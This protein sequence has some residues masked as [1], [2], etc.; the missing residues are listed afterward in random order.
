MNDQKEAKSERPSEP[1]LK[2]RK[3]RERVKKLQRNINELSETLDRIN[4][5]V[6]KRETGGNAN[7]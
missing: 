3:V 4:G 2:S 1:K 6:R 7:L 5:I